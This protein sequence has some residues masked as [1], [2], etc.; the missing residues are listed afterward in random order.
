MHIL[1]HRRAGGFSRDYN[2]G[3]D[4]A[5]RDFRRQDFETLWSIDQACFEAGIAYSRRELALYI[6]QQRSFT[7]VAEAL[8]G[9]KK[10]PAQEKGPNPAI[11]GF[12]VAEVHRAV[13]HIIT[14]DVLPEARRAKVGSKLLTAA[15]DRLRAIPCR[16][17][18]LETAVDNLSAIAFYKRHDYFTVRTLPRYYSTGV[19]ALM[20]EK[21]L[22]SAAQAG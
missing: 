11:I 5:L 14:I 20:L 4:F 18:F 9:D 2:G 15:E 3:V 10:P 17:V 16:R 13:G 6:R 7:V 1:E 12:L 21:N 22:L 8:A 19:D